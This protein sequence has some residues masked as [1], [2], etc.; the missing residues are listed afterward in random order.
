MLSCLKILFIRTSDN[1]LDELEEVSIAVTRLGY[2]SG[3]S[4]LSKL[5]RVDFFRVHDRN[6][7]LIRLFA[8]LPSMHILRATKMI[9][10]GSEWAATHS[11]GSITKLVLDECKLRPESL[12]RILKH[13]GLAGLFVW[14]WFGGW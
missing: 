13:C 2:V 1:D 9:D 3:T 10:T 14:L 12:Q 5:S 6:A 4:A 7:R 11:N 8:S